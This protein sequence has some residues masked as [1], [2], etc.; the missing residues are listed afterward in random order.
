MKTF[1]LLLNGAGS[2]APRN[3]CSSRLN[4]KLDWMVST[5]ARHLD[6]VAQ[7]TGENHED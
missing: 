3:P 7:C 4:M 1:L 6:V 2:K 5:T